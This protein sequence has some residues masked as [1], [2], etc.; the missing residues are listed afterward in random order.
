MDG[1]GFCIKAM[2]MR[3]W[4]Q[5]VQP[6]R[7]RSLSRE[8][9]QFFLQKPAYLNKLFS[10]AKIDHLRAHREIFLWRRIRVF[11]GDT[12]LPGPQSLS[13]TTTWDVGLLPLGSLASMHLSV[14]G[15]GAPYYGL[16]G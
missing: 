12:A 14:C 4:S 5:Y 3:G 6:S 11:L 8:G 1:G 7:S 10:I 2:L 13:L 15:P 16:P 9:Y